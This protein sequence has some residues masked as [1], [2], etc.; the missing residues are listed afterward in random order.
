M[1]LLLQTGIRLLELVRLTL[2]YI[3]LLEGDIVDQSYG[4]LR[5]LGGGGRKSRSPKAL[6]EY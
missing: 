5:I 3:K 2:A 6:P 1:V 4:N